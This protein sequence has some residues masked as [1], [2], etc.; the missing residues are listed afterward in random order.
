[1]MPSGRETVSVHGLVADAQLG[2]NSV[3]VLNIDL[4]E[5]HARNQ[6]VNEY[7]NLCAPGLHVT[8]SCFMLWRKHKKTNGFAKVIPAIPAP[9]SGQDPDPVRVFFFDDN[10]EW[11]GLEASPGICNLRDVSSGKFVQFTEG[12]NGFRRE[13]AG[14]HTV[15]HTSSQYQNVLVKANILDAMEDPEYFSKIIQRFTAEGERVLVYMDV[16]ATIMCNDSAQCKES[17]ATLLTTMFEVIEVRPTEPTEFRWESFPAVRL[18]TAV[19][20]KRIVMDLTSGNKEAYSSF[21]TL[22]NCMKFFEEMGKLGQLVWSADEQHSVSREVFLHSYNQ[23]LE[24]LANDVNEDGITRSWF[25]VFKRLRVGDAYPSSAI[26]LN[27]FGVD[28]RRV[29]LATVPDEKEVIQITVNWDHWDE[30]DMQKFSK[31]FDH[32]VVPVTITPALNHLAKQGTD[33]AEDTE[34]GG[35]LYSSESTD[36]QSASA[37]R[38]LEAAFSHVVSEYSPWPV[39]QLAW[40]GWFS[41]VELLWPWD[42]AEQ[43]RADAEISF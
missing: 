4:H 7:Y 15:I 29:V 41:L 25:T 39:W 19:T 24:A 14:L 5:E 26:V 1:M 17:D 21:F 22:E 38:V 11:G 13:V 42:I 23:Y 18:Q 40:G 34:A 20:L 37:F 31:Q 30:R 6:T 35:R 9:S 3:R 43:R 32:K 16:N 33:V 10:M 8:T 36:A 12:S 2:V 27:S 28:T